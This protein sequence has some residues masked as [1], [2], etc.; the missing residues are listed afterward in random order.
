M[1]HPY[2]HFENTELWMKIENALNDLIKN[3]DIVITTPKEYVIGYVCVKISNRDT[4]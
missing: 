3:K 2:Q 4:T 1:T